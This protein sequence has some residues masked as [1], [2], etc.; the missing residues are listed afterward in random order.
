[1]PA[2]RPVLTHIPAAFIRIP[3]NDAP[4]AVVEDDVRFKLAVAVIKKH[5]RSKRWVFHT[6]FTERSI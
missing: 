1:M 6:N 2:E 3:A 4:A 5:L